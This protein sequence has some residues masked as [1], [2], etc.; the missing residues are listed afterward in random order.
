MRASARP[1]TELFTAVRVSGCGWVC[2]QKRGRK[3]QGACHG[4]GSFLFFCCVRGARLLSGRSAL[5]KIADTDRCP[6]YK[7][8]QAHQG[9]HRLSRVD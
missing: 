9:F 4:D 7:G 6:V 3:A 2:N 5:R 1:V 8:K